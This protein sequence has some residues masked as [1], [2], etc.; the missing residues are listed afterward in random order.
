MS[1]KIICISGFEGSGKDTV[2]SVL[3]K[4]YQFKRLSFAD[5]L[6]K[7]LCVIFGWKFE[8]IQGLTKESRIW[9]EQVDPFWAEELGQPD[10]TPR[11]ALQL[12]GT[13][14]FRNQL[15]P[16]IWIKS[17]KKEIIQTPGNIVI[18]DGRFP[19]EI[20]AIQKMGGYCIRVTRNDPDW[21]HYYHQLKEEV[22]VMHSTLCHELEVNDDPSEENLSKYIIDMLY[23][24]HQIHPCE[25]SL[26]HYHAYH[27]TIDNTKTLDDLIANVH[28]MMATIE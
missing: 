11:K 7:A 20:D 13:N 15:H 23:T 26:L 28:Q 3:E 6:K 8:D 1:R 12:V 16:D 14:L 17:L 24:K 2:A 25:T 27:H 22:K 18:V 5:N 21:I 10:F 9:R 19:N 4:H